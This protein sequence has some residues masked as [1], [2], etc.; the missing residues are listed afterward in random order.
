MRDLGQNFV[1]CLRESP[2]AVFDRVGHVVPH[3][4]IERPMARQGIRQDAMRRV[5]FD[6]TYVHLD[7][8]LYPLSSPHKGWPYEIQASHRFVQLNHLGRQL[9]EQQ[10]AGPVMRFVALAPRRIARR[11]YPA[12]LRLNLGQL[13]SF[14]LGLLQEVQAGIR[15]PVSHPVRVLRHCL[16]E[17]LLAQ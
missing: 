16:V 14:R 11:T 9:S 2:D 12:H 1:R 13:Q 3:L 6:C 7:C 8:L 15:P 4:V 10:I 5:G 17:R